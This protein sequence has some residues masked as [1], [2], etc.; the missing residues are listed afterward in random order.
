MRYNLPRILKCALLRF[1]ILSPVDGSM[2]RSL[3]LAVCL[4]LAA[5]QSNS[6]GTASN[7]PKPFALKMIHDAG[8]DSAK[9]TNVVKGDAKYRQADEL[10]CI[11]TDMTSPDGTVPY[12]LAVWRKADTWDGAELTEGYYEWD[13]HSCPREP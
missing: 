10:W 8:K 6:G 7:D 5:C 12:L 1:L 2:R 11:A 3:I 9:I 13:L 4:L